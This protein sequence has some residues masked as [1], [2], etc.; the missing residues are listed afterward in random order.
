MPKA[1]YV[2]EARINILKK[3]VL[4]LAAI[5]L[6]LLLLACVIETLT[7]AGELAPFIGLFI[8]P[9]SF[10]FLNPPGGWALPVVVSTVI[11]FP[12]LIA[13]S[14]VG[15]QLS[16]IAGGVIWFFIGVIGWSLQV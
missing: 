15:L 10:V 2:M 3:R 11:W 8:G 9:F 14:K 7:P 13:A 16:L 5:Y 4:F 6:G 12:A 1:L